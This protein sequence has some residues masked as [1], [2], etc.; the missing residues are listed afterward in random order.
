MGSVKLQMSIREGVMITLAA[1]SIRS[2]NVIFSATDTA[3]TPT[4]QTPQ[5]NT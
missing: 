2:S 5:G 1:E 4:K 3:T